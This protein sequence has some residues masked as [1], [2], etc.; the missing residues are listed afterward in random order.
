MTSSSEAHTVS[1]RPGS[2]M[3]ICSTVTRCERMTGAQIVLAIASP[4]A[5]VRFRVPASAR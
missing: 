4:L 2:S 3:A 1:D 5:I